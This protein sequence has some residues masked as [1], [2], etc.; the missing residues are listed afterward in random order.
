MA[1]T[2]KT[3]DERVEAN[4]EWRLH[5]IELLS[6]LFS[7]GED[8]HPFLRSMQDAVQQWGALTAKQQ[9]AVEKWQ[10]KSIQ[11]AEA[12]SEISEVAPAL[13]EGRYEMTGE[14]LST[15][16]KHS[17]RY[18]AESFKMT[19]KLQDGNKVWGS[20]PAVLT[21]DTHEIEGCVVIFTAEV[22]RSDRD[23]HFGFFRRP[24]GARFA[25]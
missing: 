12:D 18:G 25:S 7:Q 22:T 4:V 2:R 21:E 23:E 14:I 3:Q 17:T 13:R 8:A 10:A 5:H 15:K 24:T 19:V 16:W 20:V 6:W 11:R 1:R 9:A